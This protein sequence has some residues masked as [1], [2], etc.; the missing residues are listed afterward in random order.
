[1]VAMPVLCGRRCGF[2]LRLVLSGGDERNRES[3]YGEKEEWFHKNRLAGA[4]AAR[5]QAFSL[6][7]AA[8]PRHAPRSQASRSEARG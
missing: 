8:S 4:A 6:E 7:G 3:G 2:G 5:W 1:M